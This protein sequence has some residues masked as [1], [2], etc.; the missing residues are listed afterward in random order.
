MPDI[1]AA[2][3]SNLTLEPFRYQVRLFLSEV[4][5]QLNIPT[6]RSVMKL[7]TTMPVAKLASFLNAE[8]ESATRYA[9]S[10]VMPDCYCLRSRA[11]QP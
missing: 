5:Q 1:D 8:S 3:G 2:S 7:Y 10:K 4:K 9:C 6:T 11:Y